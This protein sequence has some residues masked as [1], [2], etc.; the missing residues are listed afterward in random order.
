MVGVEVAGA[1]G[2]DGELSL[3]RL[4]KDLVLQR[5]PFLFSSM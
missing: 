3:T 1:F 2:E 4:Y 5:D